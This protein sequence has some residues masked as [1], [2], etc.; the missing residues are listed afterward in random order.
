MSDLQIIHST[1]QRARQRHGWERAWCG[2]WQ[3]LFLGGLLW[4]FVLAFYKLFPIP[5]SLVILAS[6]VASSFL[7]VGFIYGWTRKMSLPKTAR[8][9]DQK[10]QL[11]ERLSTALELSEKPAEENWKQL[12][13]SDAASYAQK[14]DAKKL[15]PFHL[16]VISR[17]A[18]LVLALA[19][20]LGFAP[21]YRSK[22]FRQKQ[23]E[24]EIIKEAGRQIS[25]FTRRNLQQRPPALEPVRESLNSVEQLGEMLSKNPLTRSG[26]LNDLANVTDKIKNDLKEL[27]KNPALQPLERAARESSRSGGNVPGELQKQIDSLKKDL[28]N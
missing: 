1:L 21:E 10:Q 22:D 24:K 7:I 25:D 3:G 4:L 18:L 5:F 14:L 8:W 19:A 13:I 12:L 17:W 27:G 11:Q 20:G 6:F 2:F 26:A 15:L 28:G 16:P 9:L 23:K